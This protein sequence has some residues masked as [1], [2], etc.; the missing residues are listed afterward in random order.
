[1]VIRLC[2]RSMTFTDYPL[3]V[4]FIIFIINNYLTLV[5][6]YCICHKLQ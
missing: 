4:L 3:A 1:M 5:I 2:M 6:L